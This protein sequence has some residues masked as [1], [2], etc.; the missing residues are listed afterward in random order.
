MSSLST[1]RLTRLPLTI[2]T[3]LYF[4]YY[5]TTYIDFHFIDTI[6][7]IFHEAGHTI[8]FF[9]GMFIKI[10]AGSGLQV[11]LPLCIAL[12]F[13]AQRQLLSGS[14][15]LLWVGQNILNVSAYAADAINM[16]MDLLGGD[17]VVHDWNYLLS[18]SG[19]LSHTASIAGAIYSLGIL[20]LIAGTTLSLYFSYYPYTSLLDDSERT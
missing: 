20:L 10:A 12:Y 11:A 5:A 6:N 19:L 2:L 4:W 18:T 17:N 3:C 8:F 15:C 14:L 13:F 9:A 7:L 16:Q 1:H